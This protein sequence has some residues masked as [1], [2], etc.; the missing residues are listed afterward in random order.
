MGTKNIA[1]VEDE[2]DVMNLLDICLKKENFSTR[3]YFT[4]GSFLQAM[5]Q[6][7]DIDIVIL[8]L[9]LPD[10]SGFEICKI[11]KR[12]YQQIPVIILSAKQDE[13]DKVVGLELGADDYIVK[14]FYTKELVLRIRSTLKRYALAR[15]TKGNNLITINDSFQIN[16]KTLEVLVDG[17]DVE[18]T[19]SEIKILINLAKKRGW[20]FSREQLLDLLWGADKVVVDRTIDVHIKNLRKKLGAM[21]HLIKSVCGMG[22]KLCK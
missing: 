18:L 22:Y 20:V 17:K 11:L 5:E 8:D 1:I 13:V 16:T 7:Q 3:L 12:R 9:M 19:K 2:I 21:G 10:M 6:S 15:E 14:P 4:G